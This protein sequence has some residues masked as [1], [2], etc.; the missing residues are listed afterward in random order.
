MPKRPASSKHWCFTLNNPTDEE[1]KSLDATL[2]RTSRR[3]IFQ[4]EEGTSKTP[5]YQGYLEF[6]RRRRPIAV[7]KCS[8]IHW[9]KCRDPDAAIDYCSK[10]P[11]LAGPWQY[12]IA[13]KEEIKIISELRPWQQE[14]LDKLSDEPD[15]RTVNW[16]V[17]HKGGAGKTAMARYLIVKHDAV[18]LSGKAADCFFAIAAYKEEKGTGPRIVILDYPRVMEKF[19]SFAA[20][21]KIKDGVFFSGKYE[22]KTLI[23]N[24]PHVIVF[25]N[26]DPDYSNFT[27]DR[28]NLVQL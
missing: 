17:D 15:D 13:A 25:S 27:D 11:R 3:W 28:W 8:R 14:L 5:H 2:R 20:I 21:E 26:F 4:L 7:F 18:Y 19:V 1:K 22:S 12:G 24:S 9:E 6:K 16:F 10:E 23:M